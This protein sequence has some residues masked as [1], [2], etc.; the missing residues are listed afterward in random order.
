MRIRQN[1]YFLTIAW[2]HNKQH[3]QFQPTFIIRLLAR[4]H[5]Q[6]HHQFLHTL[7][8]YINDENLN[9][10]KHWLINQ[11]GSIYGQ[12]IGIVR[13]SFMFHKVW[14]K[15]LGK[16]TDKKWMVFSRCNKND[17]QNKCI[18]DEVQM[19]RI[20]ERGGRERAV[21]KFAYWPDMKGYNPCLLV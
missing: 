2:N 17:E 7:E 3:H 20:E 4:N 15:E 6:K 21:W 16:Q 8:L 1:W 18:C 5:W 13:K 19:H 9:V 12:I 10:V 14:K 11:S